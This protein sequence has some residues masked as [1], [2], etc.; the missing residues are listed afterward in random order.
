MEEQKRDKLV[1]IVLHSVLGAVLVGLLVFVALKNGNGEYYDLV[2]NKALSKSINGNWAK[3][4][5]A[6][7]FSV[8]A[9]YPAYIILPI[10]GPM[11]FYC[12]DLIEEKYRVVF[13][14]A[15]VVL[16]FGGWVILCFKSEVMDML[17]E[18]GFDGTVFYVV[19]GIVS[20][21]CAGLSV[22]FG[23]F[24]PKKTR[25]TLFKFAIFAITYLLVALV[26]NQG[27]KML[28][29][30]MRFR[31]MLKENALGND[32]Y[33]YFTPWYTPDTSKIELNPDYEYTS[34]PSGHANS[35]THIFLLC[36]LWECLP[37]WREKKW[38]KYVLTASCFL[39]VVLSALSRI[40]DDAH[41]LSDV[42]FSSMLSYGIYRLLKYLYFR[43]G[44]NFACADEALAK[45]E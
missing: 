15:M 31:D 1:S 7:L 11:L 43:K 29:H 30:R 39:F 18:V 16:T 6:T 27:L 32:G 41:F 23:R 22:F 12:N 36:A 40:C 24:I 2:I 19:M 26:I 8:I 44:T 37:K 35:A 9:E 13:K 42:V 34:F 28:W 10:F 5:F 21:I 38:L 3:T 45:M 4:A 17:N 25:F 20:V 14:I 33:S